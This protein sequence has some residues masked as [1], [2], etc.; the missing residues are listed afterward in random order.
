MTGSRAPDTGA[1]GPPG[2]PASESPRRREAA[3]DRGR[4][5][6]PWSAGYGHAG[7]RATRGGTGAPAWRAALARRAAPCG[8]VFPRLEMAPHAWRHR[9]RFSE[10][11]G[12]PAGAHQPEAVPTPDACRAELADTETRHAKRWSRPPAEGPAGRHGRA[13]A[14]AV[15]VTADAPGRTG[16]GDHHLADRTGQRRHSS[17][18]RRR[19]RPRPTGPA[20]RAGAAPGTRRTGRGSGPRGHGV[21]HQAP[22]CR[23][24]ATLSTAWLSHRSAP[25]ARA[26]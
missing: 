19:A 3:A 17:R 22:G 1:Q 5:L 18:G 12:Q 9:R 23:P 20:A 13:S 4:T 15:I 26:A 21:E 25:T 2:S 10:A 24:A 11:W 14:G 8:C 6:Q 7:P 16:W